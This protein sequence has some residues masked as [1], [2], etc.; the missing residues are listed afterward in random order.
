MAYNL[1]GSAWILGWERILV[2]SKVLG[3]LNGSFLLL[4]LLWGRHQL[5]QLQFWGT[6]T[7]EKHIE[8]SS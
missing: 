8:E 4:S 5:L 3:C 7:I 2:E 1:R 6:E